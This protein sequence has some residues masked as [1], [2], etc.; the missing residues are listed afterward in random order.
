MCV[1][2]SE[3]SIQTDQLS[4]SNL[5]TYS[6]EALTSASQI[7]HWCRVCE[8]FVQSIFQMV[9]LEYH[10][11]NQLNFRKKERKSKR[12]GMFGTNSSDKL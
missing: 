6:T 10:N 9:Q 4:V 3:N 11:I 2:F 7:T 8:L 5:Q 1:A 12:T